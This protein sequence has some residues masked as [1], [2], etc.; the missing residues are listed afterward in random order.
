MFDRLGCRDPDV[1]PAPMTATIEIPVGAVVVAPPPAL[2]GAACA[3]YLGM[4]PELARHHL[5][6]MAADPVFGKEVVV[7][8]RRP[9][10]LAAPPGDVLRFLRSRSAATSVPEAAPANEN[11]EGLDDADRLLAEAG[12]PV[13]AP[14]CALGARRR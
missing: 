11:K 7:L 2:F 9:R 10:E 5:A 13:T 4:S 1:P 6:A 12:V 14:R 3:G 8:R